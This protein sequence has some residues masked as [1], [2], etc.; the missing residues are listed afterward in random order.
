MTAPAEGKGVKRREFLRILG[1][2]GAAGAAVGCSTGNVEKL[3]PYLVSPDNTVPGVSN[4]Y[5]SVCR[6]CA[7]GCG[8]LVETRDGRAIKIEGNVEHPLNRGALC[9]RGQAALQGLYNPDRY[10]G[11]MMKRNGALVPVT[12]DEAMTTLSQQLGELRQGGG[13]NA[14][15]IN[16]HESGSFP[17]F[18]DEWLSAFGMPPHISHDPT[19]DSATIA[20]NLN[21]YSVA[22]PALD[23]A[24]SRLIISFG[25][26]FLENWGAN[27]PQQLS[28]AD[29]RAK[30]ENAP[31]FV[32]VG[33]RRSLTGLNADEWIDCK[34]GSELLIA[35]ALAARVGGDGPSLAAAATAAD[36]PVG[37]LERLALELQS[38][39]PS[40]VLSGS[41][42]VDAFALATTVNSIN[43]LVGNVGVT[44]RPDQAI[45]SF[46]GAASD[47]QLVDLAARMQA[48]SVPALFVRGVN[49]V[50]TLPAAVRFAEGLALVP[51][52]VSFSSYPDETAELCDLVLPDHHS[53]ESWGDTQPASGV[54]ALQQPAM[55]PVFN[56]R[57]TADLLLSAAQANPAI[58]SRFSAES[59]RA[60]LV[61]RSGKSR[62]QYAESLRT[63]VTTGSVAPREARTASAA[64]APPAAIDSTQGDMYLVTYLSPALADGRGANKPW[65]QELPDPV[66]KICWQSWAE[67]H[68]ATAERLGV[69]PGDHVTVETA[70]GSLTLPAYLYMGVRP[71]TVAI[72]IGQGHT[73][74][75]RYSKD[76]GV[77]A[78]LLQPSSVDSGSGALAR[79]ST[80]TRVTRAGP[81][82]MLVTTEGSARQH[83]RG[84]A[85]AVSVAA[86]P[87][88]R[89]GEP[90]SEF[91]GDA[92]H[93]FL[94]GLRAP[95]AN[96]AQGE[97]GDPASNEKGMYSRDHYS[98][99]G[100]GARR[101]AMTVDLARCTGC[102]ACV[103]AC[104]AENNIPTVGAPTQG[105]RLF[106]DNT[107]AGAN[108]LRSREMA[109]IRLERYF[110][111][112]EN[113]ESD[114]ET[115]FV[116]MMCQHCG[117]APCEP[118]CPVFATYHAPDGLNIQ[119]YNRCVGT[120]Y[121]SNNCPYKV[122]YF[123]WFGYG[124]KTRD[125]Y[126]FPEPLNWQL[127][128]DVTVRGKGVMEKCTFCVQRIREAENRAAAEGRPMAADEFTT[129]CA[130]GCPSRAIIFGDA[131]DAGSAVARSV[132]DRRG[133]HVF[134]ELNTYSA[135][136]YLQKVLHDAP[137]GGALVGAGQ[138]AT[139]GGSNGD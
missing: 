24:A 89:R 25:A 27:V 37:R 94:P 18:L 1:A 85:R 19:I 34:A 135:V 44:I 20:A 59:Y 58:A 106:A 39:R 60:W 11:P 28:F 119:V 51:F 70:A 105:A 123:N 95:V 100:M 120:R 64:S 108:I 53:L 118:V 6:E 15:F 98:Y 21:S 55:D 114:F 33:P 84:I 104:Y 52:K 133:Y 54:V 48:G 72:P 67:I 117:N 45:R 49:P 8:I 73:A 56:T 124:E 23:F 109:W 129:A 128:P 35:R 65:L 31:R 57:A 88:L 9:A 101:W 61:E 12:W 4:Y 131:A 17:A 40:L 69:A 97:L 7:A 78:L 43:R 66:A 107:G 113:G 71:D 86:L 77:N 26:D 92:S 38:A 93:A 126:A 16:M 116:P 5:S 79:V 83:G 121:C 130:Q 10:R 111:G 68:P 30:L 42:T 102:S 75:G 138:P 14:A 62:M 74:Y 63:G 90:E 96:D 82:S 127:N 80:R 87:A 91:M 115:R 47:A 13:A 46:E 81:R 2:S 32:Y 29:A 137:A 22:W 136:V 110:E 99:S 122:R 50:H 3:I 125:Q 41:S 139:G 134:E 76:I 132:A 103:T 36:V 112:G